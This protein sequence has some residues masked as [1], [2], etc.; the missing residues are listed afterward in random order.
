[1]LG[2]TQRFGASSEVGRILSFST[3]RQVLDGECVGRGCWEVVFEYR[4]ARAERRNVVSSKI[5]SW[6]GKAN[7][8]SSDNDVAQSDMSIL[9]RLG[10]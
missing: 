1:M 6:R 9:P 3:D 10:S 5:E 4:L 7:A 8:A 2:I